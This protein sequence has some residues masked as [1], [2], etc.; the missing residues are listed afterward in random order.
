[1]VYIPTKENDLSYGSGLFYFLFVVSP[2]HVH[3][4][5]LRG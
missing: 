3:W 1:M 5:I 2:D 4:F